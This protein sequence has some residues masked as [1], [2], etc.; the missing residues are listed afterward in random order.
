[1]IIRY[2]REMP[3]G[4]VL[5][6]RDKAK[7]WKFDTQ[8]NMKYKQAPDGRVLKTWELIHENGLSTYWR[9]VHPKYSDATKALEE[10]LAMMEGN[11]DDT[12]LMDGGGGGDEN[13]DDD[14]EERGG[15]NKR[16]VSFGDDD[17]DDGR[18]EG[19]DSDVKIVM[20]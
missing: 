7:G 1:M 15:G 17:D 5:S 6:Q 20:S 13:D 2:Y 14:D 11:Y 9:G 12:S 3:E 8:R 18:T 19:S 10:R 4:Y 16:G